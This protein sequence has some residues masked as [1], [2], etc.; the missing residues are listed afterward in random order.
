VLVVLD[1]E[2]VDPEVPELEPHP[3]AT[4]TTTLPIRHATPVRARAVR[5]A[6]P[7]RLELAR[8]I[9]ADSVAASTVA[10]NVASRAD[11]PGHPH[12]RSGPAGESCA[13]MRE[14]TVESGTLVMATVAVCAAML[15]AAGGLV[16]PR[17]RRSE[18]WRATVTPLASIIGSGFL[19]LAPLLAATVGD[20]AP[21]AMI[22]I[23]GLAYLIGATVRFNIAHAEDALGAEHPPRVVVGV[24]RVSRYLLG[25][26]YM[27]SV[28]FYLRLLASFLLDAVGLE[29]AL[30]GRILTTAVLAAIATV[31]WIRGLHGIEM[32]EVP[33]VDIKLTV[34]AGLLAGMFVYSATHHVA[35]L[36]AFSR[37]PIHADAVTVVR[38]LAG[39]LLVVQGFETSRYLGR[40]YSPGLRIRT[41]RRAQ[42]LSGVIYVGFAILV[43]PLFSHLGD[44]PQETSIIDAARF[45][46]PI[47]APLLLVAA[48]ASQLSAAAADTAGGSEMITNRPRHKPGNAGYLVVT[49][50]AAV[51]VW[52]TDVFGIVSIA[53]R[54]FAA[55]YL[56]QALVAAT[57]A[58]RAHVRNARLIV[59]ANVALALLLLVI[60]VVAIPGD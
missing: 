54:A 39:M 27:I 10:T 7:G 37:H 1:V 59:V 38:R 60:A 55:Y 3:A 32:L 8:C 14:S 11:R 30:P 25:F 46:A 58:S 49:A 51:F 28:G 22:G 13:S 24:E 40:Y 12:P 56:C 48:V 9:I 18:A 21:V 19:V 20:W 23:V 57:T 6:R 5:R 41:M 26:A 47:L 35:A 29:A 53:S 15:L 34:I 42:I 33:A 44:G 2:L 31:G 4:S 36:E 50:G 52:A 17:V 16:V 43:V 45:V